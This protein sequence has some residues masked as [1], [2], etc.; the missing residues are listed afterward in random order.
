VQRRGRVEASAA[1]DQS[2]ASCLSLLIVSLGIRH[3]W[4]CVGGCIARYCIGWGRSNGVRVLEGLLLCGRYRPKDLEWI[5]A[6]KSEILG[7]QTVRS[8]ATPAIFSILHTTFADPGSPLPLHPHISS[9]INHRREAL[10]PSLPRA[11]ASI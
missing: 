2:I 3:L 6:H 5:R 7:L 10:H 4:L 8:P 11:S 9:P 1:L